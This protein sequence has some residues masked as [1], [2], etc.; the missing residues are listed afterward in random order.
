M[1]AD[2]ST[3]ACDDISLG[4]AGFAATAP[5]KVV[6]STAMRTA[7]ASAVPMEAPRFVTVFWIP[8]TSPLCESGTDDTVTAAELRGQAP[9]A[10]SG[11]QQ[12]PG[13]DLGPGTRVQRREQ[14]HDAEE[15]QGEADADDPA[16]R[17]VGEQLGD[18]D[19]RQREA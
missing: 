16:G 3:W 1:P 12:G 2:S 18:A 10:E 19:G 7:P 6:V 4:I 15:Q 8:P 9:D 13:D 17:G 14:H 11:Q 5:R